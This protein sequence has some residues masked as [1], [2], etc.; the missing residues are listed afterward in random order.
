MRRS[1]G[2]P[3]SRITSA[4]GSDV[5]NACG[6]ASISWS[7]RNCEGS[8]DISG[9]SRDAFGPTLMIM[10]LARDSP[11]PVAWKAAKACVPGGCRHRR[12]QPGPPPGLCGARRQPA[13]GLS[14]KTLLKVSSASSSPAMKRNCDPANQDQV[15]TLCLFKDL[16]MGRADPLYLDMRDAFFVAPAGKLIQASAAPD[17]ELPPVGVRSPCNKRGPRLV[18]PPRARPARSRNSRLIDDCQ[19]HQRGP[20]PP[21]PAERPAARRRRWTRVLSIPIKILR[22]MDGAPGGRP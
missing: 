15:T 7:L 12:P 9:S 6:T 3:A 11:S 8:L 5:T 13:A 17:H 18:F 14:F 1:V 22:S 20:G 16:F 10:N 4:G 2:R 19:P 21:G